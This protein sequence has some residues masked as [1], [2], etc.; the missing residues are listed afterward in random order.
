[1][2]SKFGSLSM[3]NVVNKGSFLLHTLFYD[4]LLIMGQKG[5][6]QSAWRKLSICMN[7]FE[8]SPKIST[9]FDASERRLESRAFEVN[10]SSQQQVLVCHSCAKLVHFYMSKYW[11]GFLALYDPHC[12]SSHNNLS[13]QWFNHWLVWTDYNFFSKF[14][15]F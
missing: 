5:V 8:R 2:S 7:S 13:Q 9:L 10:L 15:I 6:F 11:I 14:S 1:M 4:I 3:T 12:W